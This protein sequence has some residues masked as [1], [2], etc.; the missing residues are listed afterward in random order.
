MMVFDSPF[1]QTQI[2]IAPGTQAVFVADVFAEDFLGGAELTTQALLDTATLRV[3]KVRSK[4]V[5][6]RILEKG[7]NLHWIFGNFASMDLRLLPVIMANLCYTVL[8]YDYK[9]CRHRS[10]EK[11]ASVTGFP[12][13]CG[14]DEHGRLVAAFF[15]GAKTLWWMSEAQ[16]DRYLTVFPGLVDTTQFVLS[17][18]FTQE[19]L[20]TLRTMRE[21]ADPAPRTD[22]LVLDSTSWIKGTQASEAWCV[23]NGVPYSRLGGVPYERMLQALRR[24]KGLVYL[25]PGGDTCPRMVIEAKLLGCELHINDNVQHRHEPWFDTDDLSQ[26]ED[27]L[28]SAPSA[29]WRTVQETAM[30]RPTI[31]GYTTTLDCVRQGYPFKQCIE[32]MLGFCD[33]VVVVDGGS[34]DGTWERLQEMQLGSPKLLLVQ[35][36]LDMTQPRFALLDGQQKAR[37]RALCRGDFCWQ[38]DCDEVVHEADWEKI[39]RLAAGVP[40]GIEIVSLPVIEYWGGPSKVRV[41]VQPWKWRLSRN[42]PHITHGIPVA[43]RRVD[44]DGRHHAAPGTDGCDMIHAV[45]GEPID[46]VS[47]YTADVE[48]LRRAALAGDAKAL[49]AYEHWFNATVQGLPSVFHYSW[50]D[51]PRKIRLYRD[52]WARH[53]KSLYD[54]ELPDTAENNYMFDL[55]WSQVTDAMV[56]DRARVMADRLGGWVW[57]RKWDGQART[58]HIQCQRAQPGAMLEKPEKT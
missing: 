24:A 5:D 55:P 10:P 1:K 15:A 21:E 43:L 23:E 50:Y 40:R 46:H 45:T 20:A 22:W 27:Y 28:A 57:H 42:L 48:A 6:L 29:F 25:P 9:Y 17:S 34:T 32:S 7:R 37:A 4:D 35:H 8:E 39:G 38:M 30:R 33:Q 14:N 12:C 41:D 56:E 58:P 36:V 11:H 19:T 52:Y 16:R 3:Q 31:S 2:E 26:V 44:P 51:L 47:F 54:Q 53:W 18:V 13:D 49:V